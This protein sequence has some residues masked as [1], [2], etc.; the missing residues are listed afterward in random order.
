M[1]DQTW[2][3]W[4]MGRTMKCTEEGVRRSHAPFPS[5]SRELTRPVHIA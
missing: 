2:V 5:R 1:Y 3:P 4:E